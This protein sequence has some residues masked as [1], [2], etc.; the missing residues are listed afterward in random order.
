VPYLSNPL[1]FDH[2]AG[3]FVDASGDFRV[4]VEDLRLDLVDVIL[5]T[6]DHRGV[7]VHDRV[8][9]GVEDGFRSAAQQ[10]RFV[11][12]PDTDRGQ[13]GGLAMPDG[14]HEVAADEQVQLPKVD[15]LHVVEVTGRPQNHEQGVPVAFQLRPLV[16]DD[17]VLH[18]QLVQAELFRHRQQLRLRR[19]VEPDPHH[20][21]RLL[22]QPLV[23]LRQSCR[24]VDPLAVAVDRGLDHAVLHRGNR[25]RRPGIHRQLRRRGGWLPVV[26]TAPDTPVWSCRTRTP[27]VRKGQRGL[28][29][30]LLLVM[31]APPPTSSTS[32]D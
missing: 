10:I 6:G 15:L 25:G 16:R 5:Q 7:A 22:P 4:A 12:H 20:R 2:L 26:G 30:W 9:D 3:Q 17:R 31:A 24:A 11:L 32:P 13:V 27:T 18:G 23:G 8:Q 29:G 14:Q 21:V 1:E 19:P 28:G